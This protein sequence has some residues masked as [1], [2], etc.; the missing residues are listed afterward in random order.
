LVSNQ[1]LQSITASSTAKSQPG[2]C[3]FLGLTTYYVEAIPTL[4]SPHSQRM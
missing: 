1:S 4:Q 2:G 3:T